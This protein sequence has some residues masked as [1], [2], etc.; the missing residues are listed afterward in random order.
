MKSEIKVPKK[1]ESKE[2]VLVCGLPG[3]AYIGKL[4]VDYLIQQLNAELVGEV[5]SNYFPPYVLIGNDGVVE[6]LKNELHLHRDKVAGDIMFFSGNSQAFSP[7]GQYEM[8]DTLLDWAV[9]NGVKKVFSLAAYV[10]HHTFETHN[11]YGTATT[12][13][14]LEMLKSKGVVPLDQ[15]IIS[16]ENGLIMGLA[17]KRG[18]EGACLLGETRGYQTPTGQYIID[19]QATKAV[20]TM[21]TSILN[22]KVDMEPLEKQ[23]QDMDNIIAKMTEVE[24]QIREEMSERAKK[25]SYVT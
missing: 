24:R 14:A 25:P 13:E 2:F 10:T 22:L 23:A 6:L 5:Y 3:A 18:V 20:L 15:G 11:V 17:K 16:G 1:I 9:S 8:A 12:L 7:E 21:L 4:S 19:A